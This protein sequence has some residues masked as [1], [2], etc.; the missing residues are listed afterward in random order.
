MIIH[1]HLCFRDEYGKAGIFLI[2]GAPNIGKTS[3]AKTA[4]SLSSHPEFMCSF[5]STSQ[6]LSTL[7][8]KTPWLISVGNTYFLLKQNKS[9]D[10]ILVFQMISTLQTF[11]W[12]CQ[13]W[14]LKESP[15]EQRKMVKQNR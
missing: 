5:K 8:Q 6:Y 14:D 12:Q 3:L 2:S 11:L 1:S 10:I 13:C 4:L 15:R 9:F 7:A